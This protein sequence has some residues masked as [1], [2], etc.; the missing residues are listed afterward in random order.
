MS[1]STLNNV[2]I[3]YSRSVIFIFFLID[4]PI[5]LFLQAKLVTAFEKFTKDLFIAC[6]YEPAAAGIPVTV[7]SFFFWDS[8][9]GLLSLNN[10]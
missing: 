6:N 2:F 4:Q 3:P 10:H 1:Q 9:Y 8:I 7:Y 5:A